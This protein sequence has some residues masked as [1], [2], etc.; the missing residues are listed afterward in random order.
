LGEEAAPPESNAMARRVC[1]VRPAEDHVLEA[2]L[3]HCSVGKGRDDV[4][5][6]RQS[7]RHGTR[8]G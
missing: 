3:R 4:L 1:R 8:N 6:F 7:H 5:V 2:E